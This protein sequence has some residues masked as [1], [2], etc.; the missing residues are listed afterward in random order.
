MVFVLFG[1]RRWI[2]VS[3]GSDIVACLTSA[4]ELKIVHYDFN[5]L[6]KFC[7]F[8][9]KGKDGEPSLSNNAANYK[10]PNETGGSKRIC[11]P[12]YSFIGGYLAK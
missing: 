10:I 11:W 4:S 12:Y 6:F 1:V 8:K 9:W 2:N 3:F 5:T 7:S